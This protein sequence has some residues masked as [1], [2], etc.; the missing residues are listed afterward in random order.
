MWMYFTGIDIGSTMTKV[1]VV[2][3]Q[4]TILSSVIGPTGAEHRHLA[5]AVMDEALGEAGLPIDRIDYIVA[6]GYG[7]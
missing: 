7:R 4:E 3:E 5:L 1:V 2:D 6:T